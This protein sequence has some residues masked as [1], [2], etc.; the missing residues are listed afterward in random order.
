MS[1]PSYM[2]RHSHT[3]NAPSLAM[4]GYIPFNGFSQPFVDCHEVKIS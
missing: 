1:H 3:L 4:T 2:K